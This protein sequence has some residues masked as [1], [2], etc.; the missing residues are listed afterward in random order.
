MFP[1]LKIC[2]MR[3]RPGLRPGPGGE[4]YSATRDPPPVAGY[5]EPFRD[6][7]GREGRG[8]V[9][10]G[11][12]REETGGEGGEGEKKGGRERK[13]EGVGEVRERRRGWGRKGGRSHTSFSR[14]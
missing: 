3:L 14:N 4:A 1:V 6:G 5:G 11:E 9:R 10:G 8:K 2:Q 7:E 12:K 13:G